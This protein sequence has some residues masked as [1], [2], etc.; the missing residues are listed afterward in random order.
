MRHADDDFFQPEL[1]AAFDHLLDARH[2][3]LAAVEA[4]PLGPG[5]FDIEE[6]L[7]DL[8]LDELLEDRLLAYR[9]EADLGVGS[10]EPFLDPLP[11][12]RIGDMHVFGADMLAVNTLQDGKHF[13]QRAELKTK[14]T[15]EIDR[16][17][18]VSALVK[19]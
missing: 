10:L 15:T 17:V 11:L 18:V 5:I 19:P 2:Q 1:A 12:L 8:G 16:A 3:G 7:E 6:P 9:R 13:T 4:K 14:R